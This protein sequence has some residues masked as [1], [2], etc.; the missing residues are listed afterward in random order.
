MYHFKNPST[1]TVIESSCPTID[2]FRP[3]S[4]EQQSMKSFTTHATSYFLLKNAV[5]TSAH[6]THLIGIQEFLSVSHKTP[7]P[8]LASVVYI[9]VLN[10]V[11][12]EKDTVLH[13]I[14]N[15]YVEY[16]CKHGKQYLVLEGDAKTYD[17]I[18]AVKFE[19][20]S[21]LNWLIPYPG[22]WHLLK[23]YQI[24]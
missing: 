13:V 8:E 15:L 10:E 3:S 23:N 1:S 21:D 12:D 18:Q 2:T 19:Y 7:S 4:C 17:V 16:V 11:A 6:N 22:D 5:H 24:S 20:G 9:E 14:N